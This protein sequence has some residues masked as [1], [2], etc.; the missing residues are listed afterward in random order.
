MGI[1]N[2]IWPGR[3]SRACEIRW[4]PAK[5]PHPQNLSSWTDVFL[6]APLSETT[7][8]H[9]DRAVWFMEL[10][11]LHFYTPRFTVEYELDVLIPPLTIQL[12]HSWTTLSGDLHTSLL[13]QTGPC[14]MAEYL[15]PDLP[16]SWTFGST[17]LDPG[18]HCWIWINSAS[19]NSATSFLATFKDTA[20]TS[21][22]QQ[23]GSHI[24]DWTFTPVL[25]SA[26]QYLPCLQQRK[27]RAD[28]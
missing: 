16:N 21:L 4:K 17:L 20:I 13:K 7:H 9:E 8:H 11:G 24:Y 1:T 28:I 26:T 15:I 12:L 19:D 27:N 10:L 6:F 14:I 2:P 3:L 25:K 5:L 18:L 23:P 22:P